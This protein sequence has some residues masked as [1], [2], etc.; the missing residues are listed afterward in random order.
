MKQKTLPVQSRLD[1]SNF[2]KLA[3]AANNKGVSI[4]LMVR[5]ILIEY[6]EA[7]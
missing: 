2:K 5:M 3:D 1:Q 6:L 4:S 7:K